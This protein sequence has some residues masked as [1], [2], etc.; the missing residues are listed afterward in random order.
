MRGLGEMTGSVAWWTEGRL[1]I[2]LDHPI[3]PARARKPVGVGKTTPAFAKP[4]MVRT[5]R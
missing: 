5:R 3:D 2:A 4:L 1:G